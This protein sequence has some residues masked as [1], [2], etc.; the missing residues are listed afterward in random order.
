[1]FEGWSQKKVVL[2]YISRMTKQ[3]INTRLIDALVSGKF[4][5]RNNLFKLEIPLKR[6]MSFAQNP[7]PENK[8]L[9]GNDR[10][11][12]VLWNFGIILC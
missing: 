2:Y 8:N 11:E 7:Q 9:L 4:K 12:Q 3:K 5:R 6:R 1:M 10:S